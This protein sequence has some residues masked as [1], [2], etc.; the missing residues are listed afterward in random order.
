MYVC[1]YIYIYIYIYTSLSL[2]IYIY[3][4]L[5]LSLSL[6]IYMYIYIYICTGHP[7]IFLERDLRHGRFALSEFATMFFREINTPE[8]YSEFRVIFMSCF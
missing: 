8:R 2:S 4:Y 7:R 1:M 6:S 5:Y 3:I